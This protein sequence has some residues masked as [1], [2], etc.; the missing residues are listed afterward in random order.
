MSAIIDFELRPWTTKDLDS[1]V[2]HANNP[3]IAANM[4][5]AFPYPYSIENGNN[6]ISF[7]N[8]KSPPLILAIAIDGEA[9]GSIGLH[10]QSD[11]MKKNAELGYWLSQ[12]YWGQGIMSEAIVKMVQ[13]GFNNLDINR[14]FA[15]PFG[16]NLASQKVLEKAGFILEATI[17]N[18]FYKN[19]K[20]EDELI[21]SQRKDKFLRNSDAIGP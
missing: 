9:A 11:I 14:I 19:G 5:D 6:F 18:G 16:S 10:P 13:Y 15:R 7:A 4:T 2:K 3:A 12:K 1:L 8:S 17:K 20:F 21:Y